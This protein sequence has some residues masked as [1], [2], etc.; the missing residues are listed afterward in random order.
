MDVLH[1]DKYLRHMRK[2]ASVGD[3]HRF[4]VFPVNKSAL[5]FKYPNI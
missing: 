2:R 4:G 1:R 5:L 3:G